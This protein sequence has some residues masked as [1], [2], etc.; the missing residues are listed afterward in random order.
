MEP[1]VPPMLEPAASEVA[2][3]EPRVL[4]DDAPAEPLPRR[5]CFAALAFFDDD[6]RVLVP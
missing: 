5:L 3:L 1:L 4:C 2:D 6:P